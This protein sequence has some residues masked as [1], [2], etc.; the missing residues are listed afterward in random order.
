M[1]IQQLIGMAKEQ[2][3]KNGEHAPILYAEN[4]DGKVTM[5][6]FADL[7]ETTLEKQLALFQL[8]RE[9]GIDS[10]GNPLRHLYFISEAWFSSVPIGEKFK[11]NAPSEDPNR[12]E[13]LTIQT[14]DTSTGKMEL[15]RAEIVRTGGTVELLSTE[16]MGECQNRLLPSFLAGSVSAKMSDRE[17]AELARQLS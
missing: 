6:Y 12:K 8:G 11:Y 14:L 3:L 16:C 9:H 4:E 10:P 5:I 15:H 1:D 7:P 13:A 17:L 2:M